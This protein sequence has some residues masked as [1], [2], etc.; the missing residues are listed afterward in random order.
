MATDVPPSRGVQ[1]LGDAGTGADTGT[2][3]VPEDALD[4]VP[5]VVVVETHRIFVLWLAP[6]LNT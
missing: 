1:S 5:V 2:V 4:D 3:D 6:M